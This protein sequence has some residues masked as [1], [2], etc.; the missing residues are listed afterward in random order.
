MSNDNQHST[1]ELDV[2][3]YVPLIHKKQTINIKIM[4][5]KTQQT[6]VTSI[7]S[8][9]DDFYEE[10]IDNSNIPREH[11]EYEIKQLMIDFAIHYNETYGGNK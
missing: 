9:C 3:S 1:E 4:S 11:W 10:N 2:H 7:W 5:K 8:I 6:E